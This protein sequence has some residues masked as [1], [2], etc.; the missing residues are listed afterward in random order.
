MR[1]GINT[2]LSSQLDR[3]LPQRFRQLRPGWPI[4]AKLLQ[5][6]LELH[7]RFRNGCCNLMVHWL[8][9]PGDSMTLSA[10]VTGFHARLPETHKPVGS[11]HRSV[12]GDGSGPTGGLAP[13]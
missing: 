3:R 5:L 10:S 7:N 4:A 1:H 6:A 11:A 12:R 8:S 13:R 2:V 9:P